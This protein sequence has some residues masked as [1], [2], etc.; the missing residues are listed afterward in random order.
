LIIIEM[1]Q[2]MRATTLFALGLLTFALPVVARAQDDDPH[3][4]RGRGR[5]REHPGLREVSDDAGRSRRRGFW[6]SG[7]L[8]I[9]GESFDA[10]DGLGWS[11][12]KAGGVGYIKLGGTVSPNVLLGAELQ[13]WTARY[14]G[15]GGYDRSLGSLL[16]IVQVYPS[17]TGGF[18]FRGGLGF[19][20]DNLSYF[21]SSTTQHG[22]ALAIGVG[23][24]FP[25]GRSVSLTPTLDLMA[26][27]FDT[28]DERVLSLGLGITVP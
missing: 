20:G 11:D 1:E 5:P 2:A 25:V 8:G 21:G 7:G 13:G 4:G 15:Q 16:G 27:R 24:D 28:H 23:Y 18:W 9:G 6:F 17:A 22:A 19:A 10:H 12:G 26:Q 3:H 14:Y